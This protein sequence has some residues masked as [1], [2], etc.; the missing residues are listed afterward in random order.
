[1]RAL[2]LGHWIQFSWHVAALALIALALGLAAL[3]ARSLRRDEMPRRAAGLRWEVLGWSVATASVLSVCVWPYL[4]AFARIEV[5]PSGAW[6]VENY[7]G[8]TLAELPPREL[9]ALC[10]EDLGGRNV[11]VGRLNVRR[12]NGNV[13]RS[14]RISAHELVTTLKLL[15]YTEGDVRDLGGSR[16]VAPHR[17]GALGPSV[18]PVLA[19]ADR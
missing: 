16:V 18:Q 5:A 7:L 17:Y 11:G 10:G 2:S 13:L 4:T 14:V 12:A 3:M 1:M 9:R 6:R 15:G 8:V 19:T